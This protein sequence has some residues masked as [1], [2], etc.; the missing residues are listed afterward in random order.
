MIVSIIGCGPKEKSGVASS[1]NLSKEISQKMLNDGF[2]GKGT[3]YYEGGEIL[4]GTI[5][6]AGTYVGEFNDGKF[7]GKGTYNMDDG[8]TYV[9]EF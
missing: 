5:I 1:E 8:F 2:T 6:F 7:H 9:G 3:F 4:D